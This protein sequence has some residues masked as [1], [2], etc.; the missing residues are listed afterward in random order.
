LI[1]VE[2]AGTW[3]SRQALLADAFNFSIKR[4]QHGARLILNED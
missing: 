3:F 2:F 4:T 1:L